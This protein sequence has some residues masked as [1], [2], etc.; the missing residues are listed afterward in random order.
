MTPQPPN[1]PGAVSAPDVG[2]GGWVPRPERPLAADDVPIDVWSTLRDPWT[3]ARTGLL[4]YLPTLTAWI[5][6]VG[7]R[8]HRPDLSVPSPLPVAL[9]I[10]LAGWITLQGVVVVADRPSARRPRSFGPL[11]RLAVPLVGAVYLLVAFGVLVRL[12]MS[13]LPGSTRFP[14]V[15]LAVSLGLGSAGLLALAVLVRTMPRGRLIGA[16]ARR[17]ETLD[18]LGIMLVGALPAVALVCT[19]NH[20]GGSTFVLGTERI[21]PAALLPALAVAAV[22]LL[23]TLWRRWYAHHSPTDVAAYL[24]TCSIVISIALVAA[25]GPGQPAQALAAAVGMAWLI[26]SSTGRRWIPALG[27]VAVLAVYAV[28]AWVNGNI[29]H[30]PYRPEGQPSGYAAH[31]LARA[32]AAGSGPGQGLVESYASGRA[33]G[34]Y[35]LNVVAEELGT[36]GILL[37]LATVVLTGLFLTR[38]AARCGCGELG[39][40]A[41][42]LAAATLVTLA[43]PT[44]PL[45]WP[46]YDVDVALPGIAPDG[47]GLIALLWTVGA[48]LGAASR[49]AETRAPAIRRPTTAP[50]DSFGGHLR[51]ILAGP[52]RTPLIAGLCIIAM[53]AAVVVSADHAAHD[54]NL[55]D[56]D[57]RHAVEVANQVRPARVLTSTTVGLDG[58]TQ[59][60]IKKLTSATD[61]R[62]IAATRRCPAIASG[63]VPGAGLGPGCPPSHL[64]YTLAAAAQNAA[65]HALRTLP[66]GTNG[67]VVAL[68]ASDGRLLTLATSPTTPATETPVAQPTWWTP[69]PVGMSL[70]RELLGRSPA[71]GS[72]LLAD[73]RRNTLLH[74]GDKLPKDLTA[75]QERIAQAIHEPLSGDHGLHDLLTAVDNIIK[76]QFKDCVTIDQPGSGTMKL[77]DGDKC[78]LP[79]LVS[80]I[81]PT[82][83][84]GQPEASTP[85]TGHPAVRSLVDNWDLSR[86]AGAA[87]RAEGLGTYTAQA[88]G[89]Q[90][91]SD[92]ACTGGTACLRISPIQLATT[93]AALLTQNKSGTAAAPIPFL[94]GAQNSSAAQAPHGA[95]PWPAANSDQ[96]KTGQNGTEGSDLA[97]VLKTAGMSRSLPQFWNGINQ[98]IDVQADGGGSWSIR[99]APKSDGHDPFVIVA[100]TAPGT[101]A[102]GAPTPAS[103]LATAVN[104]ALYGTGG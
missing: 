93:F 24:T 53:A 11:A 31:A 89:Q 8:H 21:Q 76:D 51:A 16:T 12:R 83:D 3:W 79:Q 50:A 57:D 48:L 65:D 41:Q 42:G 88:S 96:G 13:G 33:P 47:V 10:G 82:N 72:A 18:P 26:A 15:G 81:L 69:Q 67:V 46:D 49:V 64:V 32:G 92:T 70:V 75:D 91:S 9:I 103:D 73:L 58:A 78:P 22:A 102:S 39:A 35:A 97:G 55:F 20:F 56:K 1:A 66:A 99:T 6:V 95:S 43:I 71:L 54:R 90:S 77:A 38:L 36:A 74:S 100:Y 5:L 60:V 30:N 7:L 84:E 4:A 44:L 85:T 40:W 52:A 25:L 28:Y 2:S 45:V 59:E 29:V 27:L 98:A 34:H 87:L 62:T 63:S 14:L 19:I 86:T 61:A 80:F 68:D 94:I 101:P 104:R 37:V 17:R 23:I